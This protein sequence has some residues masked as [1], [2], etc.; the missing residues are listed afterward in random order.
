MAAALIIEKSIFMLETAAVDV[1][2][3]ASQ[4]NEVAGHGSAVHAH[5]DAWEL[6]RFAS[7]FVVLPVLIEQSWSRAQWT[8]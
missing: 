4:G 3:R 7:A 6:L 1:S 5:D 8:L 2:P